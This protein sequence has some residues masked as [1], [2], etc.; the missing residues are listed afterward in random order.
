METVE[1][2]REDARLHDPLTVVLAPHGLAPTGVGDR[3]VNAVGPHVMPMLGG[4]DMTERVG[5]IVQDHLGI[6][7]RAARE[8][9]E[10][11]IVDVGLHALEVLRRVAH[12]GV[13]VD[14]TV[15]V[16]RGGADALGTAQYTADERAFLD[17]ELAVPGEPRRTPTGTVHENE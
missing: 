16:N 17:V 4:R 1:V 10:H 12:A 6:A 2:I 8:V 3:E 13:E 14:P 9:H 15:P 11:G 5:R 7:R